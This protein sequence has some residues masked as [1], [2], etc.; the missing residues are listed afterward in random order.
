MEKEKRENH[1]LRLLFMI[2]FWVVLRITFTITGVIAFIQWI[3]L[4]F[5][6]EPLLGLITF[7]INLRTYQNQLIKYLSFESEEKAFPFADWPN[8]EGNCIGCFMVKQ[9][10]ISKTMQLGH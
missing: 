4:W 8:K 7:S 10:L 2:L 5:Q 9:S 3:V 6:E 1:L